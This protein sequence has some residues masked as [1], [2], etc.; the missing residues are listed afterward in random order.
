[1]LS[2]LLQ[3]SFLLS[4]LLVDV[5]LLSFEELRTLVIELVLGWP[6]DAVAILNIWSEGALLHL[7]RELLLLALELKI[8]ESALLLVL[9]GSHALFKRSV[10]S[11]ICVVIE[12]KVTVLLILH[13]IVTVSGLL[14]LW[15]VSELR[16]SAES[17]VSHLVC[18]RLHII[19]LLGI[20]HLATV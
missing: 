12:A 10:P 15:R 4:L 3:I 17:L 7:S 6:L 11:K 2:L 5:V 1:M 9:L 8:R 18:L 13:A 20:V 14:K 16:L 19:E